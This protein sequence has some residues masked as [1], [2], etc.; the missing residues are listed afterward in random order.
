MKTAKALNRL[1]RFLRDAAKLGG[2]CAGRMAK[3]DGIKFETP[4][5]FSPLA[6]I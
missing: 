1:S 3:T 5:T 6:A 2:I 4:P